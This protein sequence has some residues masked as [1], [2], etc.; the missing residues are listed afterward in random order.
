MIEKHEVCVRVLGN[1]ALLPED[2]QRTIAEVVSLSKHNTRYVVV[3]ENHSR[4][5]QPLQT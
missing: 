5:C 1:I 3:S 2:V 4:G